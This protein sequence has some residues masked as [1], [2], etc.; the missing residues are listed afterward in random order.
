MVNASVAA[1]ALIVA[2]SVLSPT[3]LLIC[4]SSQNQMTQLN[5]QFNTV[6]NQTT[7]FLDNAWNVAQ[8]FQN[9]DFHYN[10]AGLGNYTAP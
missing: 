7:G 8:E 6:M 2:A 3:A 5:T 4:E 1:I 9:P 10:P